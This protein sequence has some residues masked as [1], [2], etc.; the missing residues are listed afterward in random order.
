MIPDRANQ[1][2]ASDT[3]LSCLSHSA[4]LPLMLS[5]PA[6]HIQLFCLSH[7]AVLP[8]THSGPASHTQ[9]SCLSHS[10]VLPLTLSCPASHTQLSCLSHSAVLPFTLSCPAFQTCLSHSAVLQESRP[11][12]SGYTSQSE[13]FSSS[14]RIPL[15]EQNSFQPF[16]AGEQACTFRVHIPVRDE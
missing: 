14:S 12:H 16:P 5:C 9:R 15:S 11:A 3:Q 8:F 10:A 2:A 13:T 7:S 6:S 1:Q 4:V